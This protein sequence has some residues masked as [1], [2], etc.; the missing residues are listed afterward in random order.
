MMTLF[1]VQLIKHK[2]LLE[3]LDR[4]IPVPRVYPNSDINKVMF[5][6]GARSLV[7]KLLLVL[8]EQEENLYKDGIP[9]VQTKEAEN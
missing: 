3:E 1:D 6:S 7:D 9:N 5:D 8:K 4:C 2:D